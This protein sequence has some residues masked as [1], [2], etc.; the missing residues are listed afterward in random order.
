M[1]L[2][3]VAI[4]TLRVFFFIGIRLSQDSNAVSDGSMGHFL[5]LLGS[6][7]LRCLSLSA[8]LH[9]REKQG[10]QQQDAEKTVTQEGT[11]SQKLLSRQGVDEDE[12]D[13][14]FEEQPS[15]PQGRDEH[16]K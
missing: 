16:E 15:S 5:G 7:L 13:T 3:H 10:Q 11:D 12:T 14:Q 9:V 1:P 2:I 4:R 6:L 8:A